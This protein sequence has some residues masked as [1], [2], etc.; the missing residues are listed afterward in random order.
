MSGVCTIAKL[1][2]G[3]GYRLRPISTFSKDGQR[4]E[5]SYSLFNVEAGNYVKVRWSRL[6][7]QNLRWDKWIVCRG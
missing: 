3:L 1:A 5:A 6:F 4:V 7:G 2:E